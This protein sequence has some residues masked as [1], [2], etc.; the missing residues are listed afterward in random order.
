LAARQLAAWDGNTCACG[1]RG[2]WR[3]A[4]H[5]PPSVTRRG[6]PVAPGAAPPVETYAAHGNARRGGLYCSD[7][8]RW[9]GR[10]RVHRGYQCGQSP[11]DT[12]E[13]VTLRSYAQDV[14][15]EMRAG[16]AGVRRCSAAW[17]CP[18]CAKSKQATDAA[19]IH[20]C[21]TG[22][23]DARDN[24]RVYMVTLTIPHNAG[25]E[26][27]PLRRAVTRA[28]QKTM[29]GRRV[30]QFR[31]AWGVRASLRRLEITYGRAGP[32]PHLHALLFVDRP[33]SHN[34]QKWLRVWFAKHYGDQVERQGFDRPALHATHVSDAKANGT[35]LAKMGCLELSGDITKDS[36]CG[37]CNEIAASKW[38]ANTERRECCKCGQEVSRNQWQILRD[39]S[40]HHAQRDR[41]R[42][43]EFRHGIKG[44]RRLTWSRWKGGIDLRA[45]YAPELLCPECR[46]D[47]GTDLTDDGDKYC[48]ACGCVV[49]RAALQ[50]KLLDGAPEAPIRIPTETWRRLAPSVRLSILDAYETHDIPS[51]GTMLGDADPA[52]QERWR[53]ELGSVM[54]DE[55]AQMHAEK[56]AELRDSGRI[57]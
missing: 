49:D 20:G 19:T 32:H 30:A 44:A 35:Y 33:L 1:A 26:T 48:Q 34:E 11:V 31:A 55:L 15:G 16:F 17:A 25:M 24:N 7:C 40:E 51:L 4:V 23:L 43:S 28:Y 10:S 42:L 47:V 18:S 37:G 50:Q 52:A 45:R 56:T 57:T 2:E 6:R 21:T 5:H 36:R 9:L 27:E 8:D 38:N 41:R 12:A 39:W 54:R 14:T 13:G 3:E 53:Y 46:K 29:S 22:H